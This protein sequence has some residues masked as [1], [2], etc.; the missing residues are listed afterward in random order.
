MARPG[1]T[2][3]FE[4]DAD[5]ALRRLRH[6]FVFLLDQAGLAETKPLPL[7]RQLGID[8]SLAWKIHRIA[9]ME[10]TVDIL[11]HLPG[12]GGIDRF[13]DALRK[14]KF[15]A[16][17]LA[18]VEEA[19]S[20]LERIITTHCGNRATFQMM[21]NSVVAEPSE[22]VTEQHRRDLIRGAS[23]VWG[24]HARVILRADFLAPSEQPGMMDIAAVRGFVD[25]VRFRRNVPWVM[26]HLRTADN[27]ME[28][29]R[30]VVRES[31]DPARSCGEEAP[32]LDE[33][34]SQPLPVTRRV[35]GGPGFLHDELV[36]GAV[37]ATGLVTCL[38]GE[39]ARA[40]ASYYV[41]EHNTLG[42]HHVLI[43]TPSD[44]LIFDVYV[45]KDLAT[46]MN[47]KFLLY[48]N[49][50]VGPEL[51]ASAF[52]RYRLP[53]NEQVKSLGAFPPIAATPEVRR[54]DELTSYV[55][56]RLHWNP[57]EFAGFRLQMSFPPLPSAAVLQWPL[58]HRSTA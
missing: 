44:L 10:N 25:L 27:D 39:I 47:P 1:E 49:L 14:R 9:H 4:S 12:P 41:D 3:S 34:C 23:Y 18:G 42:R 33:F 35:A 28:E 46:A 58:A 16:N 5:E 38:T 55:F 57:R 32:L 13:I 17:V 8:K 43:R 2:V 7:A 6:A 11:R 15:T 22:Q 36:E 51:N 37:G 40:F 53:A 45:H 30:S 21:V 54:Y 48:S 52:E 31:I 26:S 24:A 50:E 20:D 29:R 56:D 19:L